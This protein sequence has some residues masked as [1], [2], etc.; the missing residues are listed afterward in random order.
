M[1][2]E[3]R[4]VKKV[5][6]KHCG[7]DSLNLDQDKSKTYDILK[8]SKLSWHAKTLGQ[9]QEMVVKTH[10]YFVDSCSKL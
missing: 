7:L 5:K 2:I 1:V 3:I 9:Y 10:W 8:L 6:T 4:F